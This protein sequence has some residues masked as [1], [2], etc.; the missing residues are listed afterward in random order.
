MPPKIWT[1][2]TKEL[3]A[4]RKF[5]AFD[6]EDDGAGRMYFGAVVTE[7]GEVFRFNDPSEFMAI[8]EHLGSGYDLWAHNLEYDI[9]NVLQPY[10]RH[11]RPLVGGTG[12]I[13]GV[14]LQGGARFR[15]SFLHWFCSLKKLGETIGLKKMDCD[16]DDEATKA[17]FARGESWCWKYCLRDAEICLQGMLELRTRYRKQNTRM[18]ATCGGSALSRFERNFLD[19]PQPLPPWLHMIRESYYGGR[20][21]CFALGHLPEVHAADF[22]S[23]YPAAMLDQL[24]PDT[25]TAK[26]V[27]VFDLACEGVCFAKVRVPHM[28]I[29]PLPVRTRAGNL[30]PTGSIEGYWTAPELRHAIECG[31]SV[32]PGAGLT[33]DQSFRPF[34]ELIAYHYPLKQAAKAKG[35]KVNEDVHK[36][37]MNSLYGMFGLSGERWQYALTRRKNETSIPWG[38]GGLVLRKNAAPFANQIWSAYITSYVRIRLHQ[39]MRQAEDAGARVCYC[40][41]DSVYYSGAQI[42]TPST[43]LGALS[44]D[45]TAAAFFVSP[46]TYSFGDAIKAKGIPKPSLS[47]IHGLASGRLKTPLKLLQALKRDKT[48]NVWSETARLVSGVYTRR[49]DHEDGTTGPI[50]LSMGE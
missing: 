24:F 25:A 48:P 46:K 36:R 33:F 32:Q 23:A 9:G 34:A 39:A 11:C 14:D 13:I 8:V 21:E 42:W 22:N 41:T 38:R 30:Y 18:R 44:H 20:T 16:F 49:E 12:R 15:D 28:Q 26:S 45:G 6:T 35:E 50:A 10:L 40:D 1:P 5:A 47:I 31:C 29:P 7:E 43:E 3:P 37:F 17:A 19:R 2:E 4:D 27:S